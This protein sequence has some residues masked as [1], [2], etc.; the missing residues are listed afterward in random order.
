MA[1]RSFNSCRTDFIHEDS[2]E[3]DESEMGEIFLDLNP[4]KVLLEKKAQ[5]SQVQNEQRLLEYT[6]G[7]REKLG[8]MESDSLR[9]IVKNLSVLLCS[10]ND[11]IGTQAA[12]ILHEVLLEEGILGFDD[13]PFM[14]L[15]DEQKKAY[16]S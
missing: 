9:A 1:T 4:I 2:F 6:K 14:T 15:Q 13:A 11:Q 16:S 12:W 7:L 3:G 5:F 10:K 8:S